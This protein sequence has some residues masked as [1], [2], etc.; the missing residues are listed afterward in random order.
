MVMSAVLALIISSVDVDE[1]GKIHMTYMEDARESE[2]Q[3]CR[4]VM[5]S[6][7]EWECDACGG[8]IDWDSYDEDDP[9][10][11]NYCPNCGKKAVA[12][13]RYTRST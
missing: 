12:V 8:G 13:G 6:P 2:T 1:R 5:A 3:T 4:M 7:G 11:C 10:N 9:P